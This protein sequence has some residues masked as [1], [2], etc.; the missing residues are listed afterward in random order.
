VVDQTD[1]QGDEEGASEDVWGVCSDFATVSWPSSTTFSLL[2]SRQEAEERA[3]LPHSH[4][5]G[6][7]EG[8]EGGRIV[9]QQTSPRLSSSDTSAVKSAWRSPAPMWMKPRD[10]KG[11]NYNI[12]FFMSYVPVTRKPTL[13][14]P[15]CRHSYIYWR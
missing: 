10:T 1:G 2:M 7:L 6:F 5:E 15:M 14:I 8:V 9:R 12:L 11:P 3:G 13:Y 4:P